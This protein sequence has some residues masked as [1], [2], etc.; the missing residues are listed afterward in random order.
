MPGPNEV[1]RKIVG[2]YIVAVYGVPSLS[3]YAQAKGDE[4]VQSIE[5]ALVEER[6]QCA[7]EVGE[8][9]RSYELASV[10]SAVPKAA[11]AQ[12]KDQAR[13]LGEVEAKLRG[14]K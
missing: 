4:L 10:Q 6:E 9:R 14:K 3:I 5:K 8:E 12:L 7:K 2:N 13:V 1:A 11:Q